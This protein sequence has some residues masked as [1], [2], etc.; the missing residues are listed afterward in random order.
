MK[1][2]ITNTILLICM[3]GVLLLIPVFM[4]HNSPISVD[5]PQ[6]SVEEMAAQ[7]AA[8]AKAEHDAARKARLHRIHSCTEDSDCLIVDKDP[9]GCY[10]GPKGVTAINVNYITDFDALNSSKMGMK[11]CPSTLSTAA[12]CS[13]SAR[14]VCKA[15]TCAIS[16]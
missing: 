5:I 11:S 12:E 7:K 16:Y 3:A 6:L 15:R 14:A 8:A 2:L 10:V 1:K 9:C 4:T 13:P